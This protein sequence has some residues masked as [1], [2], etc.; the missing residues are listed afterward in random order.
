[1]QISHRHVRGGRFGIDNERLPEFVARRVLVAL[2][3][4]Q[5]R[6][7][8]VERNVVLFREFLKL[9][10]GVLDVFFTSRR[11]SQNDNGIA[12]VWELL[13]DFECFVF[14]VSEPSRGQITTGK[15]Y[16]ILSV[17]RIKHDRLGQKC[18]GAQGCSFLQPHCSDSFECERVCRIQPQRV[19]VGH[20]GFVVVARFKII[21]GLGK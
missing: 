19:E 12:I 20:L 5:I 3:K 10:A 16:P 8:E 4:K 14:C 7:S 11:F 2:V 6:R 15:P 13:D 1:M 9:F 21:V 17:A 18:T